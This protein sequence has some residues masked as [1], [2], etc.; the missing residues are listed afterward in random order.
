MTRLA[1][2]A[3]ILVVLLAV[4]GLRTSEPPADFSFYNGNDVNTLDP[5]RMSWMPDMRAAR[6]VF[7]PLVQNDVLRTDAGIVPA[8]ADRW[9]VSDDG[10]TYTFH[11][12]DN[13]KWSNGE[14][15]TADQFVYA[16]R[17][18]MLPDIA[19]D[20]A[21]LFLLVRGAQDFFDWRADQLA[22][23]DA[24]ESR[25]ADGD[26]LWQATL[27]E[28]SELVGLHAE[29]ERT[30]VVELE[31]PVPYFLDICAFANFSPV[32]PPLVDA[33]E[34]PDRSTGRLVRRPGWTRPPNLIANGPFEIASWR[35]KREMRL[36]QNPYWWNRDSLN[37]RSISIPA[38]GDPNAAV[39]AYRTGTVDLLTDVFSGYRGEMVE[40]KRAFQ[41]EHADEIARLEAEGL[42]QYEIDRRLPPDPRKDLHVVPA[43]GTYFWNFNCS[44]TLPDGRPNPFADARVR[45]A[46]SLVVDKRAIA[47]DVRRMGEPTTGCLIPVGSIPGYTPPGGLPNI[48]DAKTD[49]EREAIV[50]RARAL[51]ADAGYPD[52]VTDF[53]I[54][55]GLE[56]NKD[57]G[58]DL[59]AQVIANCWQRYLGVQVALEQ[60]ELKVYRDD[61]KKHRFITSRAGWFGDYGDPTTFLDIMQTG[62]G[63]NDRNYSNPEYDALLA[64]A[65]VER[66]PVARMRIL[67]K[68]ER[69]LCEDELPMIPIF[70]Y[71]Q[72]YMFDP[73]KITGV[74][75]NART[76][77]NLYL[78]DVLGDGIG[79]DKPRPMREP[80]P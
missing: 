67:E 40:A 39:L 53:P 10:L 80:P 73:A 18:G 22:K 38:I 49:A 12:R 19:A 1:V 7:E 42:D 34:Q 14:P 71:V 55:V 60:K 43:F 66:D 59:V 63:N 2:I 50:K 3:A 26:A 9:T 6:L 28:F 4:L 75:A 51:L 52:P 20:Y 21:A 5:Q 74:S 58:H 79:A 16:W 65:R 69:M 77:Q 64:S 36:V 48:G 8:A 35:F 33:Y 68:A 72:L 27:E 32:Y 37:I 11:V 13:A 57:S 56:F 62:D 30:L 23:M 54:T 46:F 29:G 41:A 76:K 31:R 24:G 44:P 17:R 70:H 45:R 61:L 25:F 78:I 15:V 47:E